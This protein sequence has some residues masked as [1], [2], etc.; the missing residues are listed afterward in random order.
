MKIGF[1]FFD[2]LSP[3][4]H[5]AKVGWGSGVSSVRLRSELLSGSAC[6]GEAAGRRQFS[7][8]VKLRA[9]RR[10]YGPSWTRAFWKVSRQKHIWI[11]IFTR[12]M[13]SL[14]VPLV[15]IGEVSMISGFTR[16]VV[17]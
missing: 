13:D 3:V 14:L 16:V 11:V 6:L 2:S 4:C 5:Q 12:V 10:N 1:A 7:L 9:L 17:L 15:S 8:W